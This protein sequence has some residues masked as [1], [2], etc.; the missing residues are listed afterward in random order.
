MNYLK[1]LLID[2]L[3]FL[4]F[5]L[6]MFLFLFAEEIKNI[7]IFSR[8]PT[9]FFNV[10]TIFL[11]IILEAI[12]FI[13]LGVFVSAII[14]SF[15]SENAIRRLLPRNAYLAII[16][17]ALLGIVFPICECAIIPVIRRLI[18]K[19]MPSHVGVVFMLS[20]PI[21]NP[22]VYASTYFAF[23][24]TPYIANARMVVGFFSS[25]IIGLIIYQLFKRENILKDRINRHHNHNHHHTKG[26]RL[27]ETFYHASDELFDTG[28]Y[29][30]IG[31][32]IASLFQAFL[33]RN[34]LLSI[35]TNTILAPGVMMGFAYV[36][37][38]CSSAD[39][40]VASSF[41]STFTEGA[42]LA[43]L[44]FGP[45][46]DIKNT[47]MLFAYFKKKFV[48]YLLLATPIIV[49]LTIFIFQLIFL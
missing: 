4:L 37:S 48:L 3:I 26:N 35:G 34:V 16:P 42:L 2:W 25:I 31:A 40:F 11:S 19:G 15:V 13:L 6:F 17:A 18:K 44:V 30:F 5:C 27:L 46:I 14:Q 21:I 8:I 29:L 12:P 32:F 9:S 36:L 33:D 39:A 22:V 10:N 23:K 28:K 49:Y 24:S 1:K 47:F 45:M 43:F 20:A 7:S 41:G 38:V